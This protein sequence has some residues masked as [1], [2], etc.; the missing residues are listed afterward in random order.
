MGGRS[1]SACVVASTDKHYEESFH[2]N[3]VF[4]WEPIGG[5]DRWCIVFY[6]ERLVYRPHVFDATQKLLLQISSV[7]NNNE[8]YPSP[9]A[10]AIRHVVTFE[11]PPP[12]NVPAHLL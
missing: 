1:I 12:R 4:R 3:H 10:I 9:I 6:V 2:W 8:T 7:S 11:R 5:C